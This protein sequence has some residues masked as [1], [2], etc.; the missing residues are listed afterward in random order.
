MKQPLCCLD[1]L[2]HYRECSLQAEIEASFVV[3]SYSY[4]RYVR[5]AVV[6]SNTTI[7]YVKVTHVYVVIF[8]TFM[9]FYSL[10]CY[11]V[12]SCSELL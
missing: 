6:V 10:M 3:R 11:I 8:V 4:P 12:Y 7:H 2:F 9:L 1:G 5:L